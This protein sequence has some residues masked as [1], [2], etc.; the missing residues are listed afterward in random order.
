MSDKSGV[1]VG[2]DGESVPMGGS[3]C[4]ELSLNKSHVVQ[5][6]DEGEN[7]SI[8][9]H[10]ERYEC[11]QRQDHAGEMKAAIKADPEASPRDMTPALSCRSTTTWDMSYIIRVVNAVSLLE[12]GQILSLIHI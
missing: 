6:S 2:D 10:Q 3:S 8:G 1:A 11:H 5:V 12:G 4:E 9:D 7:Q